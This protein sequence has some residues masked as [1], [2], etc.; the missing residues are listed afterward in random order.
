MIKW[1]RTSRL[2]IKI[3]LSAIPKEAG[4]FYGSFPRKGEVLAYRGTSLASKRTSLGPY[5]RPMP[6][7]LGG[8]AF[9]YGRGTPV[10]WETSDPQGS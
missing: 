10:C 9:S 8:W 7:F 3:S 5:R 2:S 4:L 6:R 1:N